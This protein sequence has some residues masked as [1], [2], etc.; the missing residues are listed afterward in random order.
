MCVFLCYRFL[1]VSS[2]KW[3]LET[4]TKS[5]LVRVGDTNGR[6]LLENYLGV[7]K[8]SGNTPQII[9]FVHRVFHEIFSIHF[10]GKI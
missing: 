7:S 9:S 2:R 6:K 5:E 10:G 8:N 1:L 3:L 4:N